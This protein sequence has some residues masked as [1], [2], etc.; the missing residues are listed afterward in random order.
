M[1]H[2]TEL[3]LNGLIDLGHPVPVNVAPQARG[4]VDV[5]TPQ[6][7]HEVKPLRSI[8]DQR[9]ATPPLP[10]G[11]EGMPHVG[12]VESSQSIV[13]VGVGRHGLEIVDS[14][15]ASGRSRHRRL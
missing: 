15:A 5:A 14:R 2:A 13:A 9:V 12:V 4:A 7:V 6:G 8:N 3:P 1:A 11:S 10:H